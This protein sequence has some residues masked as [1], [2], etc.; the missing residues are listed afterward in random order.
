MAGAQPPP[1]PRRHGG[2]TAHE[3]AAGGTRALQQKRTNEAGDG[4][5]GKR[6]RV[7][8]ETPDKI[9]QLAAATPAKFDPPHVNQDGHDPR[10]L[11]RYLPEKLT[12]VAYPHIERLHEWQAEAL[13][14]PGVLNGTANLV[15]CAPTS[16]GKSL[17]A[18]VLLVRRACANKRG[19]S[20]YV[21]PYVSICEEKAEQL[22]KVLKPEDIK[23][24]RAYSDL[25]GGNAL[26]DDAGV[27]IAT[28]ERACGLVARLIESESMDRLSTV[29]VDELHM[30]GDESRGA[31]LELLITKVLWWQRRKN[32]ATNLQ[33]LAMSATIPNLDD[34]RK[35]LAPAAMYITE[36]RP[37]E[38]RR[39]LVDLSG[40]KNEVVGKV[41]ESGRKLTLK[42]TLPH[43]SLADR[44]SYL[45]YEPLATGHSCLIFCAS[46]FKC[47]QEAEAFCKCIRDDPEIRRRAAGLKRGAEELE[48]IGILRE[49]HAKQLDS[50]AE[51][52]LAACVRCGVA[53]HHAGQTRQTRAAVEEAYRLG[54][55]TALFA[56]STLAAGVNLP[57]RRVIFREPYKGKNSKITASE[58][59]QMAGRAGR[60]GLDDVGEA[61]LLYVPGGMASMAQLQQLMEAPP[62]PVGSTLAPSREGASERLAEM[63]S[64]A[65]ASGL[66]SNTKDLGTLMQSTLVGS[67]AAPDVRQSNP[68]SS[69]ADDACRPGGRADPSPELKALLE[70]GLVKHGRDGAI[71]P[72]ELGKAAHAAGVRPRDAAKLADQMNAA[73]DN[74]VISSSIVEAVYMAMG[75]LV[76]KIEDKHV[77]VLARVFKRNAPTLPRGTCQLRDKI[78]L[79]PVVLSRRKPSGVRAQNNAMALLAALAVVEITDGRQVADISEEYAIDKGR[80][81]ALMQQCAKRCGLLKRFC[82]ANK[83][84][85]LAG[86]FEEARKALALGAQPEVVNLMGIKGMLK[87]LA[88]LLVEAGIASVA[89]VARATRRELEV[90]VQKCFGTAGGARK[91]A[92]ALKKHAHK[93]IQTI[94]EEDALLVTNEPTLPPPHFAFV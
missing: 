72:T 60:A 94:E 51:K 48:R 63:V 14:Q 25:G 40:P 85:L 29:V 17:V 82:E 37:V 74:G 71:Q 2:C 46:K 34:F 45:I 16:G 39:Y 93:L 36:K 15:Y 59:R 52:Q 80:L 20:F 68:A 5:V 30:V 32:P 90:I 47:Q 89:A 33:L 77:D 86:V 78:G 88:T 79:G 22:E 27:V 7:L 56:T 26:F 38:L 66:V 73:A 92:M 67:A 31:V 61:Y 3:M 81:E 75:P 53:W 41:W 44:L 57:A 43:K 18:E 11:K 21:L 10:A 28:P 13:N 64:D 69:A 62:D 9:P 65:I 6:P 1:P 87:P 58:Y 83:L 91:K 76:D 55:V 19:V 23:V 12:G 84:R 49:K 35:W 70:L 50:H 54:A 8:A 42:K 24:Q 4:K